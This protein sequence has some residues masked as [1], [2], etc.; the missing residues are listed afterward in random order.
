MPDITKC[1]NE[2]CSKKTDC[3]RYM[4]EEDEYQSYARFKQDE[5]G[6]CEYFITYLK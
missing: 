4:C 1:A 3:Y 5:D 2:F 6:E